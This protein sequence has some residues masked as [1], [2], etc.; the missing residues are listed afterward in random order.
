MT[1]RTL[2]FNPHMTVEEATEEA[3]KQ[4]YFVQLKYINDMDEFFNSDIEMRKFVAFHENVELINEMKN[5]ISKI[6]G[7]AV[8]YSF[9]DN[10][11]ITDHSAQ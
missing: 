10:I 11:E 4:P 1:Y 9:V 5:T 8:S 3:K 7:L 6:E 2:A